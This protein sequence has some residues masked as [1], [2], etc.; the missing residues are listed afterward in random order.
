MKMSQWCFSSTIC[1]MFIGSRVI[2]WKILS[3]FFLPK[4]ALTQVELEVSDPSR[5]VPHAKKRHHNYQ[6]L[7]TWHLSPLNGG[8]WW[9]WGWM[10]KSPVD[11]ITPSSEPT[12]YCEN[13]Q[14]GASGK[15]W[16]ALLKRVTGIHFH[17]R[18]MMIFLA[19]S[20]D[21]RD[22]GGCSMVICENG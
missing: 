1:W 10:W 5:H 2:L 12:N 17:I 14:Q 11:I 6:R 9:K 20:S 4:V 19:I 21:E 16:T 3:T 13:T 7:W 18:W 15:G 8:K 22:K